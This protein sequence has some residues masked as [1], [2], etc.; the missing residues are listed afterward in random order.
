[1]WRRFPRAQGYLAGNTFG[2]MLKI[3]LKDFREVFESFGITEYTSRNPL[4]LYVMFKKPPEHF[5]RPYKG[6]EDYK[7]TITFINGFTLQL[8]S[9]DNGGL[10]RGGDFD[11]G[12]CDELA[13]FSDMDYQRVL[14]PMMRAN[15]NVFDDPLH[16]S[17][18]G[19]TSMPREV[20][21]EWIYRIEELALKSN[22]RLASWIETSSI[23]N[24]KNLPRNYIANMKLSMVEEEF[25][26]EVLNKRPEKISN[27]YYPSFSARK[28]TVTNYDYDY[29]EETGTNY[30]QLANHDYDAEIKATW[31]FNARFTSLLVSQKKRR[32]VRWFDEMWRKEAQGMTLVEALCHDFCKKYVAHRHKVIVIS[33]DPGGRRK[34]ENSNYSSYE[35]IEA[36]FKSYGWAVKMRPLSHYPNHQRRHRKINEC[37]AETNPLFPIVQIDAMA[38]PCLIRSIRNAP[39]LI[40]WKKDKRSE[41]AAIPQEYATHLSDIFDYDIQEWIGDDAGYENEVD[42]WFG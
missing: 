29:D 40:D 11:F 7:Y 20:E 8:L 22:Q 32:Y 1:M 33:G 31:D 30:A 2:Q 21:G 36:V 9:F 6:V 12:D 26:I 23:D 18:R 10:N 13:L 4:G 42:A 24:F 15:P 27:S 39:M 25:A 3:V 35:L 14:Q 38:C 37:F 41:L 28:H 19:Y 16:H 5:A 34:P 17:F